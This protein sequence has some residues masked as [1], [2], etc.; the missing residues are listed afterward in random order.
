MPLTTTR[1][2]GNFAVRYSFISS[3]LTVDCSGASDRKM[4]CTSE[5]ERNGDGDVPARPTL[6]SMKLCRAQKPLSVPEPEVPNAKPPL[7]H[8]SMLETFWVQSRKEP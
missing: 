6:R 5:S 1:W 7:N 3:A 8:D 4:I 2:P